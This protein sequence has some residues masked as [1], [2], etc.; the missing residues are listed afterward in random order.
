MKLVIDTNRITAALIR[1]NIS[2]KIIF[3][4]NMEFV[5]P[6]FVFLEIEKYKDEIIRKS[7][8][9]EEEFQT[10]FSLIFSKIEISSIDEHEDFIEN[11]KEL[12]DDIKDVPFIVVALALN[13]DGIWS[14]DKHFEKQNK[15]KVWKTRDLVKYL[16]VT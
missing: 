13:T 3:N 8:I 16:E 15:I 7:D 14:D 5:S 10:M 4:Q 2:R 12:I 9:S 6:D 11:A 1:D